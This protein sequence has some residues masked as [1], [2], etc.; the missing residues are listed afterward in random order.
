[1]WIYEWGKSNGGNAARVVSRARSTGLTHLFVR[2]GSSHDHYT[3]G[4]LLKQLLP[5]TAHTDIKVI[6][7]DFPE[8]DNPVK[9]AWRLAYAAYAG[10]NTPGVPHVAAVAPDIETS[11]EGTN[12]SAR[13]VS[14]YLATLRRL[15]PRDVAILTTVPS[16]SFLRRY[17][18][19]VQ[20]VGQ[21]YDGKLDVPSIPHNN[22]RKQMPMFFVTARKLRASAVS[23]WSWQA[24]PPVAWGYLS[25]AAKHRWFPAHK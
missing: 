25:Y 24:A 8:L 3:G 15:L 23:I 10:Y 13:T 18:L 5:A 16:I 21:G 20:P 14:I 2:T 9:D 4:A 6:A 7:W 12:T 1:M 17:K 11:A 19:P 22:L